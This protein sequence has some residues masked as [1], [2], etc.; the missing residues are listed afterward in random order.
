MND[1]I[2]AAFIAGP[3]AASLTAILGYVLSPDRRQRAAIGSARRDT[4]EGTW[5]GELHQAVDIDGVSETNA[6]EFNL[7][8]RLR[9]VY[10]DGRLHYV[11]NQECRESFFALRGGFMFDQFL[12]LDYSNKKGF[13]VQFGTIVLKL[14]SDG[15]RLEGK[16][17]GYG[18]VTDRVIA[19]D[20]E[21]SRVRD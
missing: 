16:L 10:G 1:T 8:V 4:L 19:A 21:L 7:R 9:T 17:V 6:V 2:W 15:T 14:H 3:A 13:V 12:K 11:V 20:L 18:S 5:K